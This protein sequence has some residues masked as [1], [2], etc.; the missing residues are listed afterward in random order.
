MIFIGDHSF[1]TYAKF[2]Y[3]LMRTTT[4]AHQDVKNIRWSLNNRNSFLPVTQKLASHF[5]NVTNKFFSKVNA[6]SA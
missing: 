3:L 5:A 2:S 1:S 6:F 4:Y